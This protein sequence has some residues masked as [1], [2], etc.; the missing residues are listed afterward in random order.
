MPYRGRSDHAWIIA[1]DWDG[2]SQA[3]EE[4]VAMSQESRNRSVCDQQEL[5]PVVM[6]EQSA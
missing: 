3:A 5:R 6:K 1:M 2:I 4:L